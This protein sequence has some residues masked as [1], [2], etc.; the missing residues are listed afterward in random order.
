MRQAVEAVSSPRR[1]RG[2]LVKIADS[3]ASVKAQQQIKK[4]SVWRCRE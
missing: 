1:E 4:H 3:I 2:E